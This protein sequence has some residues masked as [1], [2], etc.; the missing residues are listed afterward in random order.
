MQIS[1]TALLHGIEKVNTVLPKNPSLPII[2]N[3]LI[4]FNKTSCTITATDL[5]TTISY[6]FETS[7]DFGVQSICLDPKDVVQ[8][9]KA[10]ESDNITIEISTGFIEEKET[11]SKIFKGT[12]RFEYGIGSEIVF[13]LVDASEF[14]STPAIQDKA[15]SAVVDG[16]VFKDVLYATKGFVSND[17]LRPAMTAV[18]IEIE[19][20][21]IRATATSGHVLATVLKETENGISDSS[22]KMEL[23]ISPKA[24]LPLLKLTPDKLSITTS[25]NSMFFTTID[26]T[27]ATV[28]IDGKYPG[29]RAVIPKEFQETVKFKRD[30]FIKGLKLATLTSSSSSNAIALIIDGRIL[31]MKSEDKDFSKKGSF[32][33]AIDAREGTEKITI[34]YNAKLL[35]QVIEATPAVD[36]LTF[37]TNAKRAAVLGDID[38]FLILIMPVMLES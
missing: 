13:P 29:W 14:P 30:I 38:K 37:K 28:M 22:K 31:E 24:V 11:S 21:S 34:G 36:V 6:S 10:L 23:L 5:E 26:T 25:G 12:L 3:V 27:I 9:L 32:K 8:F 4:A 7:E 2:A 15:S 33:M 19:E 20:A 1:R 17:E 35:K 18:S 16:K